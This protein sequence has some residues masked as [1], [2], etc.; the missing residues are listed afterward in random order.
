MTYTEIHNLINGLRESE[1]CILAKIDVVESVYDNM[2][3]SAYDNEGINELCERIYDAWCSDV[4]EYVHDIDDYTYAIQQLINDGK[5]KTPTKR[6][7]DKA[8]DLA[9]EYELS[10]GS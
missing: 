9:R 8:G 4:C 6:C 5:Y 3:L 7:L 10:R 1:V 2:D